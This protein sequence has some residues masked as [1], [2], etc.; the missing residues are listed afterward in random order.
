MDDN[1]DL[2]DGVAELLRLDGAYVRVAYDGPSAI[3]FAL[4]AP[5]DILLC[6]L[7]LPGAWMVSR[8]RAPVALKPRSSRCDS[9]PPPAIVRRK[10]SRMQR[11]QDLIACSSSL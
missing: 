1:R 4:D 3:Q 11:A 5:P 2:A 8:W 10:P 6:D 9:S 7:G